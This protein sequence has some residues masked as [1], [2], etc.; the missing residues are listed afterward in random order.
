MQLTARLE[1]L[2]LH[3]DSGPLLRLYIVQLQDSVLLLFSRKKNILLHMLP[4]CSKKT[5][6]TFDE[7]LI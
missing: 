6:V 1:C 3:S 5:S 7:H 2:K 4:L